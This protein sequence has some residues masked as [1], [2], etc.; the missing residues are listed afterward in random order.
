[1]GPGSGV[2]RPR[3]MERPVRLLLLVLCVPLL[4]VG[5]VGCRS[6][7]TTTSETG[8]TSMKGWELY[9]W[10][11]GQQWCFSLLE[12]TNREKSISEIRSSDTLLD[13]LDALR[14]ALEGIA[15]GQYIMWWSPS[16]TGEVL[17][18]PTADVVEQVRRTCEERGLQLSVDTQ[19]P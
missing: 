14:R 1:M 7:D 5:V 4:A 19:S 17:T 6:G 2:L 13:G 8:M 15:A 9:S 12:G 18:F 10:Q 11:E 3:G 16:W